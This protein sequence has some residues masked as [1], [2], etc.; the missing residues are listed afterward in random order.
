MKHN[1]IIIIDNGS[2]VLQTKFYCIYIGRYQIS[3]SIETAFTHVLYISYTYLL[4]VV[5]PYML[6]CVHHSV[7]G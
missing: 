2:D 1:Y 3:W 5:V 4:L 6:L 7:L